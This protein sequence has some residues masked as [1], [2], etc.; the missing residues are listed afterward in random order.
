MPVNKKKLYLVDA[1]AHIYRAFY[2]PMVRMNTSAGV[3]TTVPFLFNNI[4]RR[5]LKDYQ[6]DYVG[7]VFDTSKPTFRDKLFEE[8]KAH[9]PKMPDELSIQLPFVRRLCE[10]MR[11]PILEWDGFEADDVLGALAKQ[12]TRANVDVI[13]VTNDKD[14]LQLVNDGVRVLRTGTGAAKS[15]V[16]VDEKKVEEILG[17][18]PNKV[19]DVMA[20]MGDSIDNIPGARDPNDKPAPGERRKPGIGEVGAREIILKFGSAEEALK[21]AGEVKRAS[22][23]EALQK[24]AKY[25]LLSKELSKIDSDVPI[26][27]D[28]HNLERREPDL[29]LLAALYRELGFNSLLKELGSDT[30][31]ATAP[32]SAGPVLQTNYLQLANAAEFREYLSQL[33]AKQPVAIWLNLE[34]GDRESEGFGT[35]I[36]SIEVSSRPGEGRAVWMDEKGEALVALKPLLADAT[37]P[38]I[39]H[40]PKLFHLLAGRVANVQH[41]TQ[42]YSYLLRPTTGNH[43]FTDVVM[44]QFN[45]MMGGG[46]GERAD[47]LQRLAPA[48]RPQIGDEQAANVYEKIDLPLAPVLAEME[49]VGI[50]VDPKELDTMSRT[51]ETEVRRLEKEVWEMAGMEFNVNSPTQLA[52]VLF[53]K[54]NLQPSQRRGR[55]KGRSTAVEILEEL[56]AKHPLP[57]KII[58]YR[59]IAKLKSTYVDSLPKLIN[60][61]TNRLH[62]SYS[63]TNTATGRLSSSDPNLQNIPIRTELGRQIRAAFVADEGK[64]LL[65]A[66]YSQIEL[67]IMAH[68]SRDPVLLEAFNSGEDI[69]ARTAQE[70]FGVGKMAQTSEHRRAAKVIN[71]GI[72]YGLSP[73]GLAQQLNIEQREAAKFISA[74]FERYRGVK[75]YLDNALAET[76]TSGV[77]KTLFGRIRPIPEINSA[78][79]QLRN[80]AERTALNSPLQGTAADVIKLAMISIDRRLA[81]ENLETKMIL[82]VHD[83]LVFEVPHNEL[84]VVSKLVREEMG[85]VYKMAVPLLVEVCSGPNWRDLD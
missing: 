2:A 48:L 57:R 73:F 55:V 24:N 17:V 28:L 15:D 16:F 12:A 9:R 66:D 43:N 84:E 85:G 40:D 4:L 5:I 32:V 81:E 47:F 11:L 60:H 22:Y 65:S 71:F 6:P 78:Q 45:S 36:A 37:R 21:R 51:M 31:T 72:I 23:R 33:T 42:I 82:Q 62:T 20:L 56:S 14:M 50:R 49:R 30:V 35:R 26:T 68:F 29:K 19:T 74:Y 69:H 38:K 7:I 67:R 13:L 76:R 58:E 54:L 79:F 41:A 18:P 10:A 52:E 64:V 63:Q 80:F 39:V 61:Q 3:P 25:V 34:V 53:D 83:E 8:Y 75:D 46:P 44:R 1:M 27:L 77:A 70:V 59:E